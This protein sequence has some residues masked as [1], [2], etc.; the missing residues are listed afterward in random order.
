MGFLLLLCVGGSS[1]SIVARKLGMPAAAM[2]LIFL[3]EPG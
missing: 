3:I 2:H 1:A